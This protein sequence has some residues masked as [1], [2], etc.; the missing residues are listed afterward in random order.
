MK[1]ISNIESLPSQYIE[2]TINIDLSSS[3]N[4]SI[5]CTQKTNLARKVTERKTVNEHS[6][7]EI[8]KKNYTVMQT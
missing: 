1:N 2:S 6:K 3:H 4:Y 8:V 7:R 5:G